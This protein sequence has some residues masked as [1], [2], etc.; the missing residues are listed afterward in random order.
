MTVNDLLAV[1]PPFDGIR[2]V[3]VPDRQTTRDI[4]TEVVNAHTA[5]AGHYDRLVGMYSSS[6]LLRQLFD[7]CHTRLPYEAETENLQTSRSP[8]AILSLRSW[9]SDCKHYAGWIAGVIDAYNRAG[10]TNHDWS[11]RFASYQ[12][13]EPQKEHVFVVVNNNGQEIW[14]DP[15]PIENLDGSYS[16]RSFNDRKIIPFYITDKWPDMSLQRLMGIGC[17][18]SCN[19]VG[20]ALADIGIEGDAI[21]ASNNVTMLYPNDPVPLIESTN[22]PY[23]DTLP[24]NIQSVPTTS[25]T[26]DATGSPDSLTVNFD[27][28]TFVKNNP[29]ETALVGGAAVIGLWLIFKKKKKKK[30]A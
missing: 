2:D 30:R 12:L 14:I 1:L 23:F 19:T 28:W 3:I 8:S 20:L 16:D 4:I 24:T 18:S 5:F 27:L 6:N 15:A 22:S 10:F 11:Y 17:Y 13:L 29:V 26:T 21:Y 9:G 25:T 7:F